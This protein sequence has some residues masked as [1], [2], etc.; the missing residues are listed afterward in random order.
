MTEAPLHQALDVRRPIHSIAD[1]ANHCAIQIRRR[2][3]DHL[4][5]F[6]IPAISI[7]RARLAT[8]AV[9]LLLR[10]GTE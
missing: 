9:Q 3:P 8:K 10:G 4:G 7:P 1:P 6:R 5:S 2:F